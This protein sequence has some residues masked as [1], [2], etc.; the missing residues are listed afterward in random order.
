MF[1]LSTIIPPENNLL[2]IRV[3][4]LVASICSPLFYY[5]MTEIDHGFDWII[6]RVFISVIGLMGFLLTFT[7]K[8]FRF[9][10]LSIN[11]T[12]SS[13]MLVYGY[14]LYLNDWSVFYRWAYFVVISIVVTASLTWKDYV[15]MMMVGVLTPVLF[16]KTGILTNLEIFHFMSALAVAFL[17][18]GLTLRSNFLY[19]EEVSKLT[20]TLIENSK[21]SALGEMAASISHEINNP[22]TIL[23][24]SGSRIQS[25]VDKDQ[26]KVASTLLKMNEAVERIT[27]VVSG[28]KQYSQSESSEKVQIIDVQK[29]F[30]DL[31]VLFVEKLK[32]EQI[33]LDVSYSSGQSLIVGHQ[34]AISHILL[35][36]MNNAIDDA[37]RTPL[38]RKITVKFD[39]TA[40]DV[41]VLIQDN[42]PGVP[43]ELELKVFDPFFTTKEVGEGMGLGLSTSKGMARAH[44]GDLILDRSISPSS[45]VLKFP[46]LTQAM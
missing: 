6:G 29:I 38:N 32:S 27:S 13:Y 11:L 42:G 41:S 28:L 20:Q 2:R 16:M 40:S 34:S 35:N 7:K 4:L 1:R 37:K 36:L 26:E 25:L 45:F 14:L 43:R 15:L 21:L 19:Q 23:K 33:L 10:R 31:K 44:Q 30:D 12:M 46:R 39:T 5:F 8:P 17:V 3:I 9:V 18:I 22:L 24:L